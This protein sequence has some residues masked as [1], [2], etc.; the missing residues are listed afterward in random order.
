MF[1]HAPEMTELRTDG[2]C[3]REGLLFWELGPGLEVWEE[4]QIGKNTRSVAM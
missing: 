4:R 3:T 1:F 2:S